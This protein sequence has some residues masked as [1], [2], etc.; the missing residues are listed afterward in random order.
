MV[1]RTPQ[2]SDA[3][4]YN[5]NKTLTHMEGYM[6]YRVW[7]MSYI[8]CFLISTGMAASDPRCTSSENVQF[9]QMTSTTY[10][11]HP[12]QWETQEIVSFIEHEASRMKPGKENPY[13]TQ[14]L[15][16]LKKRNAMSQLQEDALWNLIV[17]ITSHQTKNIRI[18]RYDEHWDLFKRC[19]TAA[20][21]HPKG[22]LLRYK[23]DSEGNSILIRI[24][25]SDWLT[26]SKFFYFAHLCD[27]YVPRELYSRKEG[28]RK[29][30][31]GIT[32]AL[33]ALSMRERHPY[34]RIAK[35]IL[36]KRGCIEYDWKQLCCWSA[37]KLTKL[38][39]NI[40]TLLHYY[41]LHQSQREILE[42]LYSQIRPELPWGGI[43]E[44]HMNVHH[45]TTSSNT[46]SNNEQMTSLQ[47]RRNVHMHG[48]QQTYHQSAGEQ[49][50]WYGQPMHMPFLAEHNLMH[51]MPNVSLS[52]QSMTS[53]SIVHP[54]S[55]MPGGQS[56]ASSSG[57]QQSSSQHEHEEEPQRKRQR[58]YTEQ[59]EEQAVLPHFYQL[60]SSIGIQAT[61][62]APLSHSH[63]V[64]GTHFSQELQT[65]AAS[66]SMHIPGQGMMAQSDNSAEKKWDICSSATKDIIDGK[67]DLMQYGSLLRAIGCTS[68]DELYRMWINRLHGRPVAITLEDGRIMQLPNTFIDKLAQAY[69]FTM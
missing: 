63:D 52:S 10:Q 58:R 4:S 2:Q 36:D 26:P 9:T 49:S 45:R 62:N 39:N 24:M 6:N 51:S 60:F 41:T 13:F 25:S 37:N 50:S 33:F 43:G 57:T 29:G 42:N 35:Y 56:I 28:N 48:L 7:Y 67:I 69:Q 22:N 8:A 66:H 15:Y 1:A 18:T 19:L 12:E 34:C 17:K 65:D 27:C 21:F 23:T 38:K 47:P 40:S 31:K 68:K 44:A 54:T 11:S 55:L 32:P 5:T 61:S 53:S 16:E 14:A 46:S 64:T 3:S 59:T 30:K 20:C